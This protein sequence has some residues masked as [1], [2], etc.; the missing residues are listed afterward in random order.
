MYQLAKHI[1]KD[2]GT[3][4]GQSSRVT[5]YETQKKLAAQKDPT[6]ENVE[7]LLIFSNN[8]IDP[9]TT[10]KVFFINLYFKSLNYS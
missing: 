10:K 2:L 9:N 1:F 8:R 5:V 3:I 7:R 4:L 6:D